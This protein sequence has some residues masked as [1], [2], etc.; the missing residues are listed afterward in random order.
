V[1]SFNSPLVIVL[2]DHAGHGIIEGNASLTAS[3]KEVV[4]VP[5]DSHGKGF[6]SSVLFS[7][8]HRTSTKIPFTVRV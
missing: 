7:F 3:S 4:F 5:G 2:L 1:V 8:T 6:S